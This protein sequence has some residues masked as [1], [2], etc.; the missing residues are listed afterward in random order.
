MQK[1]EKKITVNPQNIVRL[2]FSSLV[3]L[4]RLSFEVFHKLLRLG[5]SFL[6]QTKDVDTKGSK[7]A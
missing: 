5:K 3:F 1:I 7:M 4:V 2:S 6:P